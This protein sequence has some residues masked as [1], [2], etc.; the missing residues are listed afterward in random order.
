[1]CGIYWDL[2][3]VDLGRCRFYVIYI[4]ISWDWNFLGTLW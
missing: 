2:L 1:M 3:W 4:Y